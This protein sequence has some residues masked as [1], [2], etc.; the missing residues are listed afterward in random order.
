M[1]LGLPYRI[2]VPAV[3]IYVF[4][5]QSNMLRQL[6]HFV[7]RWLMFTSRAHIHY[8]VIGICACERLNAS[9]KLNSPI[10]LR[11]LLLRV[12]NHPFAGNVVHQQSFMPHSKSD[13]VILLYQY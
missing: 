5:R 7:R 1:Y 2:R 6:N 4:Q 13:L 8:F 3:C 12:P 9:E 10:I 11:H